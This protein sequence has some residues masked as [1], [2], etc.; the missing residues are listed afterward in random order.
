[1]RAYLEVTGAV[2]CPRLK[3]QERHS[4]HLVKTLNGLAPLAGDAYFAEDKARPYGDNE[5]GTAPA[6]QRTEVEPRSI[7][8]PDRQWS[9]QTHKHLSYFSLAFIIRDA[10]LHLYNFTEWNQGISSE[11]RAGNLI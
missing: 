5:K 2:S 8:C 9:W 1:M 11:M 3:L 7:I 6:I 4:G 10:G